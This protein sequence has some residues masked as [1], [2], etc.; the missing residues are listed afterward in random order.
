[1]LD[2]DVHPGPRPTADIHTCCVLEHLFLRCRESHPLHIWA[3]PRSILHQKRLRHTAVM[4]SQR[5]RTCSL[6]GKHARHFADRISISSAPQIGPVN[7]IVHNRS[8]QQGCSMPLPGDRTYGFFKS[9]IESTISHTSAKLPSATRRDQG[10]QPRVFRVPDCTWRLYCH[11]LLRLFEYNCYPH[12]RVPCDR[13]SFPFGADAVQLRVFV[14]LMSRLRIDRHCA[15]VLFSHGKTT[16]RRQNPQHDARTTRKKIEGLLPPSKNHQ[17]EDD[18]SAS[19]RP[20]CVCI[21]LELTRYIAVRW[22]CLQ[23]IIVSTRSDTVV[24]CCP[25]V[26]RLM[27]GTDFVS[28]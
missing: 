23:E 17:D 1:M 12:V 18:N 13:K 20:R 3:R 22:H 21:Y 6:T 10:L 24:G 4:L 28:D 2:L 15:V 8:L 7:P 26:L 27:H 9:T 25:P 11:K 5:H 19:V 14:C 16:K